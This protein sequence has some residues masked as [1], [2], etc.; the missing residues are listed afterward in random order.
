MITNIEEI[1]LNIEPGDIILFN[2]GLVRS[3]I[4]YNDKYHALE[5]VNFTVRTNGFETIESLLEFYLPRQ[6]I[7]VVTAGEI[8]IRRK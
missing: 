1:E 6:V 7:K 5:L 4:K 8:E 2:D 3:I